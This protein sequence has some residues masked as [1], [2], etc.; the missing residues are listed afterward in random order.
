MD[1][2]VALGSYYRRVSNEEGRL[3]L[4]LGGVNAVSVV[5]EGGKDCEESRH[6]M[7]EQESISGMDWEDVRRLRSFTGDRVG[8]RVGLNL[9]EA[10][11]RLTRLPSLSSINKS[12]PGDY[13]R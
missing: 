3:G 6:G 2:Q 9:S 8:L 5:G 13:S 1:N 10:S 12:N 4:G 7:G 11:Q